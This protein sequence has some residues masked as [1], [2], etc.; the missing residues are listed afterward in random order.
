MLQRIEAGI[1]DANGKL[2]LTP[3][4]MQDRAHNAKRG[5][6][7]TKVLGK[8]TLREIRND[9]ERL[10]LPSWV[11]PAPKHPGV[12]KRGK[13]TADQW[14]TFCTINLV[15]TLTRLWGPEPKGSRKRRML[16]NFMHLV[17]AIKLANM[18]KMTTARILRYEFHIHQY[19]TTL[20]DLY[21][22]TTIS[23][24]QHLSLHYGALLRRFGPTHAWRC[25]P[26]ERYNYLLQKIPTNSKFGMPIHLVRFLS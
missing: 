9:M 15:F 23:P 22:G 14:R 24:Y 26:F 8:E 12:S 11:S 13:F 25:F 20:L 7:A 17:T 21:P 2:V 19:L 18:R 16:D 10:K 6:K 3:S 1:V 4:Q 5:G